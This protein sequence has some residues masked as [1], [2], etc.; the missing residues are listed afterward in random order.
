MALT[1]HQRAALAK[2]SPGE[3]TPYQ[4][5]EMR[6]WLVSADAD[7]HQRIE[8]LLAPGE[9]LDTDGE[10]LDT[11]SYARGQQRARRATAPYPIMATDPERRS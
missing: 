3:V 5:G 4:R 2:L 10:A 9:A 8:A 11:S 7:D 1:D 6:A